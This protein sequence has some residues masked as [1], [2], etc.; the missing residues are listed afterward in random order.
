MKAETNTIFYLH[1]FRDGAI[2]FEQILHY[3][4]KLLKNNSIISFILC[5]L[6]P[7]I[8]IDEYQDT[9]EIQY[10]IISIILKANKGLSKTLIVGDPNQSIYNSLG[11]YP[12]N[13]EELESL[14]GFSL[15][16][17]SLSKNYRSSLRIINYFDNYKTFSNAI[18]AEGIDKDFPSVITFNHSVSNEQVVDEIVKLLKFNIEEKNIQPNEICIVAPQWWLLGSITRSLIVKLPNL[19][20]NGPGMAPFSRDIDNFWFKFSRIILTEPS[21]FLYV[22]RLRWSKEILNELEMVGVNLQDVTNKTFLR[23]CNS[24]KIDKKN[25]LEYLESFFSKICS[26]LNIN[27]SLF[28]TLQEH[29]NAFFD[30]SKSRIE[31]L[32]NEGNPFIGDIENFRKVFKQREGITVSTIHGVKGEEYDTMIGFG[33]LDTFVPHFADKKNGPE[34]SKKMLYV[35]GSRARKNLHLISETGRNIHSVYRPFG[36]TPTQH[37]IDYKYKY[38]DI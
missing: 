25:G 23:L 15:I 18:I 9:K 30:S 29:Y 27:L 3:S 16:E 11:G 24:I 14:L 6:F 2:D 33:L 34:N 10:H 4:Y 1:T 7:F 35:L 8:L 13:K 37:L 21:P 31:R 32:V 5:K 22:R 38:D 36:L 12:M 19:S 20:F 28:P 17:M 26:I